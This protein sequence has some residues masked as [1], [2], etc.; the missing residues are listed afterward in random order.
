M[1]A[2]SESAGSLMGSLNVAFVLGAASFATGCGVTPDD[3]RASG[4]AERNAAIGAESEQADGNELPE[5]VPTLA[6]CTAVGVSDFLQSGSEGTP[7]ECGHAGVEA[8]PEELQAISTCALE[9]FS[10][11]Q[12]FAGSWDILGDDNVDSTMLIGIRGTD[13]D[14]AVYRVRH[15]QAL[16]RYVPSV[17][18]LSTVAWQRCTEL[19]TVA[20]CGSGEF[21]R[22]PCVE[23]VPVAD[24]S[25]ACGCSDDNANLQAQCPP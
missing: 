1:S 13:G 19:R 12:P 17:V 9:A 22:R 4:Q 15:G 7:T 16:G 23:C 10:E 5:T 3:P 24:P 25:T 21:A 8:S 2:H 20:E 14:F 11:Q 6:A 18:P